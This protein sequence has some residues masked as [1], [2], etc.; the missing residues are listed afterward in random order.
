MGKSIV[1]LTVEKL[2]NSGFRAAEACPGK[3][4]PA[5]TSIAV[6]VDLQRVD[7]LEKTAELEISV[8]APASMGAQ[9]CQKAALSVGQVLQADG[10]DCTQSGCTF[11]GLA[12]LFCT[13]IIARYAGTATAE[14][15]AK[16]AGFSV[17]LGDQQLG[18]IVS[19]TV[20]KE[21]NAHDPDWVFE[22]EEFFRPEDVEEV[23]AE[24]PFRIT[25]YRPMQT[26]IFTNC[27][28]TYQHRVTEQTGTRQ[29]RRGTAEERAIQRY[30]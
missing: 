25:M 9:A 17:W 26:E 10:A 21:R 4:L 1:T 20:S 6:A 27:Y 14:D 18:S 28:W 29:I 12:N 11:D 15:W 7:L 16:R 23:D 13:R 19:L 22:L 8:L 24:E 3:K 2:K 5:L 30:A